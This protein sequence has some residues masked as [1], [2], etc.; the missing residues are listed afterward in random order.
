MTILDRWHAP[1]PAGLSA[2]LL[3]LLIIAPVTLAHV[4]PPDPTWLAG[5]YDPADFDDVVGLLT[6][7]FEATD[8]TVAPEAGPCLA[9]APKLCPATVAWPA[10]G[11]AYSAL[12]LSPDRSDPPCAVITSSWSPS[13]AH[14]SLGKPS[15][16]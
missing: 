1:R 12:R 16:C 14:R 11:P 2:I 5:V 10:S 6:S 8:S 7:A 13:D 4:S 9:L 3:V 15:S